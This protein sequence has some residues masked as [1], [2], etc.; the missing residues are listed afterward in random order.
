MDATLQARCKALAVA[1]ALSAVVAA[2][3]ETSV[4]SAFDPG[5]FVFEKLTGRPQVLEGGRI[6]YPAEEET[7]V[8]GAAGTESDPVGG[9]ALTVVSN[10]TAYLYVPSGRTLVLRGGKGHGAEDGKSGAA[11]GWTINSKVCKTDKGVDCGFS[12][13]WV[14]FA[15]RTDGGAGGRAAGG[16]GAGIFVHATAKLAIFGGGR[17]KVYGGAG[18]SAGTGQKDA[19]ATGLYYMVSF[20]DPG[21]GFVSQEP[22]PVAKLSKKVVKNMGDDL[23]SYWTGAVTDPPDYYVETTYCPS[24]GG[25][26]GGGA[27]GG[28]AAIG[29]PGTPGS[30]GATGAAVTEPLWVD[31]SEG[32]K[33][34]LANRGDVSSSAPVAGGMG[35]VYIADDMAEIVLEGGAGGEQHL[36]DPAK[37]ASWSVPG[38]YY[39][40]PMG[41]SPRKVTVF[42]TEG[43]PGGRGGAGGKGARLGC[44]GQGGRGGAGGDTGSVTD[45]DVDGS[46]TYCDISNPGAEGGG[47]D[48]GKDGPSESLADDFYPYSVV[49][50]TNALTRASSHANCLF[51]R[52]TQVAVPSGFKYVV[53]RN[54]QHL[55][56]LPVGSRDLLDLWTAYASETVIQP[57]VNTYG[58]VVLADGPYYVRYDGSSRT[59]FFVDPASDFFV[60]KL[61]GGKMSFD[62]AE[63]VLHRAD[64]ANGLLN[65]Q[66]YVLNFT[67][68]AERVTLAIDPPRGE[69]TKATVAQTG[70]ESVTGSG[71]GVLY[72]LLGTNELG[73][74][75]ST[76]PAVAPESES[77]RFEVECGGRPKAFF[78]MRL[79]FVPE[80]K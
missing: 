42:F 45:D 23:S 58:D 77:R 30:I 17:L 13:P 8:T 46:K 44:G 55:D 70:P 18:G 1:V 37:V 49:V 40:T 38:E 27:G 10:A 79:R 54:A 15:N 80:K 32:S 51:S 57:D 26:G 5:S 67:T 11:P 41:S 50:F 66:N 35:E 47:G 19:R 62:E 48:P 34:K 31:L 9:S 63:A 14:T 39:V 65:W 2:G 72:K 64:D 76:W 33:G 61:D 68:G 24:S 25:G 56:G 29:T 69:N 21:N 12:Y 36:D 22:I 16:G 60:R 73:S 4:H 20:A 43:Q 74:A 59:P 52:A 6:Y 75:A 7:T 28:G 78:D 53:T 71:V 3:G